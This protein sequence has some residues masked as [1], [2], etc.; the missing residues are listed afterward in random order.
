MG[1][2]P[3]PGRLIVGHPERSTHCNAGTCGDQAEIVGAIGRRPV[4]ILREDVPAPDHEDARQL[5]EELRRLGTESVRKCACRSAHPHLRVQQVADAGPPQSERPVVRQPAVT[6]PRHIAETRALEPGVG[7]VRRGR[8]HERQLRSGR[9][10][11]RSRLCDIGQ[12]L[13]TEGSTKRS[14]EHDQ[15]RAG[16]RDAGEGRRR[17]VSD[18]SGHHHFSVSTHFSSLR[19]SASNLRMPSDNF[20]TAIG[21]WLCSQR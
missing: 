18:G 11:G 5:P 20:S 6:H 7:L 1:P 3:G 17:G 21:S 2:P 16:L 12:R 19:A 13:A 15:G 14:Q 10:D 4:T 8:V 9:L